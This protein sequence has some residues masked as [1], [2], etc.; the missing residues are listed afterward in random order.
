MPG[1]YE[2]QQKLNHWKEK[3]REDV[4]KLET[5]IKKQNKIIEALKDR[6]KDLKSKEM[7]QTWLKE[8][9]ERIED[10]KKYNKLLDEVNK[11]KKKKLTAR[12]SVVGSI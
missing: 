12:I 2:L 4:G 10:W 7:Y 8:R 1:F 9:R 6:N 5:Q 11:L 3:Y